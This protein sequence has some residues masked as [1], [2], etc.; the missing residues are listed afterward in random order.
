MLVK[1]SVVIA[2]TGLLFELLFPTVLAALVSMPHP[3]RQQPQYGLAFHN[4]ASA[5]KDASS[6]VSAIIRRIPYG[7]CCSRIKN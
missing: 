5:H 3:L 7:P 2:I 1:L 6:Q 4:F